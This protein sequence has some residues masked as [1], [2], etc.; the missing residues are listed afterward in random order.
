MNTRIERGEVAIAR[1]NRATKCRRNTYYSAHVLF[2]FASSGGEG[3]YTGVRDDSLRPPVGSLLRYLLTGVVAKPNLE[4]GPRRAMHVFLPKVHWKMAAMKLLR[5]LKMD[6][7]FC[8]WRGE[9]WRGHRRADRSLGTR[10]GPMINCEERS[11]RE[12]TA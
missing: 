2:C 3:G 1:K 12:E 9:W 10:Y 6:P 8:S 5:L 7:S 4:T 11:G